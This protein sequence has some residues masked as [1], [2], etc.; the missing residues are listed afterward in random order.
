MFKERNPK[1]S[2]AEMARRVSE[3]SLN[4]ENFLEGLHMIPEGRKDKLAALKKAIT[5][6]AYIV[7]TEDIADKLL[8]KFLF[9]LALTPSYQESLTPA[10]L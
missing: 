3:V 10:F 1:T 4:R 2:H 6:G 8:K 7:H 9:E 5:E